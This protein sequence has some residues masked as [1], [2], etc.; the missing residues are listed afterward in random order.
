MLP[1]TRS[2][3]RQQR[4]KLS[5]DIDT[6]DASDQEIILCSGAPADIPKT[7]NKNVENLKTTPEVRRSPR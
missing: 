4:P 7:P 5:D 6:G 3:I 1:W 2:S